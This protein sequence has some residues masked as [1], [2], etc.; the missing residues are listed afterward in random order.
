MIYSKSVSLTAVV[1][2]HGFGF[3]LISTLHFAQALAALSSIRWPNL[4][5]CRDCVVVV[6]SASKICLC[7]L[8]SCLKLVKETAGP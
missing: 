7:N 8:F 1:A 3:D 4:S 6:H 5:C 2:G